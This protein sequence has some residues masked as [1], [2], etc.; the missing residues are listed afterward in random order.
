MSGM[1]PSLQPSFIFPS[2]QNNV[3]YAK[4]LMDVSA[5]TQR[6]LVWPSKNTN[7]DIQTSLQT[8]LTRPPVL[9]KDVL[10]VKSVIPVD[11]PIYVQPGLAE[12]MI[13]LAKLTKADNDIAKLTGANN[14]L[15]RG[16]YKTA[17]SILGRQLT[18]EEQANLTIT[19]NF[20]S[21]EM[22]PKLR[23]HVDFATG[24]SGTKIQAQS[25]A[26]F[27]KKIRSFGNSSERL[28]NDLAVRIGIDPKNTRHLKTTLNYTG[29]SAVGY[30]EG[31][32]QHREDVLD[33]MQHFY[34]QVK[35]LTAE[36]RKEIAKEA[37]ILQ[38]ENRPSHSGTKALR[39]EQKY[40]E[41]LKQVLRNKK[42]EGPVQSQ[43]PT[44]PDSVFSNRG[45]NPGYNPNRRQQEGAE[46]F[47]RD[48]EEKKS[49][50]EENDHYNDADEY[51]PQALI[52]AFPLERKENEFRGAPET[53]SQQLSRPTPL[54]PVSSATGP[55]VLTQQAVDYTQTNVPLG[56]NL[57]AQLNEARSRLKSRPERVTLTAPDRPLHDQIV[58]DVQR[59]RERIDKEALNDINMRGAV[60]LLEE[61][62]SRP[63]F[64]DPME[65]EELEVRAPKEE[66]H[67]M[68]EGGRIGGRPRRTLK[69]KRF[70]PYPLEEKWAPSRNFIPDTDS[71]SPHG[72]VVSGKLMQ[73]TGKH[74]IPISAQ[75]QVANT[76]QFT[77]T[78][79]REWVRHPNYASETRPDPIPIAQAV[80]GGVGK[81][82]RKV[83]FG[84]YMLDH[85]KLL[86]Q[87]V[88]SLSHPTGK[89]VKGMPNMEVTPGLK[90]VIHSIVTGGKVSTKNLKANEKLYLRDL[91]HKSAA[92][93]ELGAD[94][95]VSP[96]QQLSLILG[97]IEAGNDAPELKAQLRKLLPQLK[98]SKVLSAEQVADISKHYL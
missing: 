45:L 18:A 7:I 31:D 29:D 47:A 51:I 4:G 68:E 71:F 35:G 70:H 28:I 30:E 37:S 32:E 6:T 80:S 22:N 59:R 10:D 78:P 74:A 8:P 97:E 79:L 5:A 60:D 54:R 83:K 41:Q 11:T 89:K 96:T 98:R 62:N 36:E 1:E 58:Q 57:A 46:Q 88:L 94:V 24:A 95:N 12:G 13:D 92:N 50:M 69:R 63:P 27:E 90:Q 40:Q 48:F 55:E 43:F 86:T 87:N 21:S 42:I 2:R 34:N 75:I 82:A 64:V 56:P 16:N 14:A 91:L 15:K 26:N 72:A 44:H 85:N 93:V 66:Q 20:L 77:E 38:G 52:S 84:G 17:E 73:K 76:H 25:S 19:P 3:N 81:R 33:V 67:H 9:D 53:I 61:V 23:T 65:G 39:G 49:G